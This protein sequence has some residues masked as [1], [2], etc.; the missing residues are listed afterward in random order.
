MDITCV[1]LES[2]LAGYH[3][4]M[5]FSVSNKCTALERIGGAHCNTNDVLSR[6]SSIWNQYVGEGLGQRP[7]L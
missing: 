6:V 3:V 1:N 7:Y 5:C 2:I 4:K